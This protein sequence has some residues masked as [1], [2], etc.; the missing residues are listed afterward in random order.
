MVIEEG[1]KPAVAPDGSPDAVSETVSADPLV[2]AVEI[3]ELADCPAAAE[4]LAGLAL[5]EKSLESA[6]APATLTLANATPATS[7]AVRRAISPR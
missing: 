1:L 2:T 7:A 6:A 5:I 4:T 3:V